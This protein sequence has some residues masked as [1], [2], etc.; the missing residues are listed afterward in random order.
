M[1]IKILRTVVT[2]LTTVKITAAEPLKK[3]N[4]IKNKTMESLPLFHEYIVPNKIL[5]LLV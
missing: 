2:M 4:D 3:M 1:T 5:V